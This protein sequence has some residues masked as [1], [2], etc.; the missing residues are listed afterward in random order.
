VRIAIAS[1]SGMPTEFKD[2]E[3]LA[4]AIRAQ[5]A[6]AGIEAWDEP[7][8]GWERYDLVLI[9]S[10]WNYARR[11]EQFLAWVEGLGE[12]V[13]NAPSLVRRNS[14]KRYL[15]EL[16]SAGFRVGETRYVEPKDSPP[17]LEGEVAV[18]PTSRSAD[19][20]PGVSGRAATQPRWD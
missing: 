10:T 5:G 8:V 12:R 9:R 15:G 17:Q 13:H 3:R 4:A 18:K 2:D 20:R 1:F 11:R 7:G 14:D 19:A 6:E 16:A